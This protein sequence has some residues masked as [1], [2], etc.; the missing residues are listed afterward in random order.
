M[1]RRGLAL[2]VVLAMAA[3]VL[4]LGLAAAQT[5][6]FATIS[7]PTAMG[8]GRTAT[9]DLTASGGPGDPA[10][11][12][13]SWYLTGP[14]LAG[15][16]PRAASPGTVSG[17]QSTFRLNVTAPAK[18]QTLTL[19]VTINATSGGAT[20]SSTV[21]RSIVVITPIVLSA[22]FRNEGS[23]AAV[24]VSVRFYVDDVF[25][26][27]QTIARIDAGGQG[28][29]SFDYLPVGLSTGTHRVRIEADLD[30][31]GRIDSG[32]GEASVSDVFYKGTP[33]LS[34]GVDVLIGIAVFVPVFLVTAALRRREK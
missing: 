12:S 13:V 5:P 10:N 11:Y 8:P 20:E 26:G 4:S 31:D 22:S 14:D 23:T 32:R 34:T 17:T 7:G 28:S 21:E 6:I 16:A 1:A 29:A 33:G 18:E 15:A 24:N 27:T 3:L 30:H 25:V 9:Y 19:R 2:A